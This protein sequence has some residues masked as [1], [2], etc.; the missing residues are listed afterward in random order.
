M[1]VISDQKLSFINFLKYLIFELLFYHNRN[2]TWSS[3]ISS[4][5]SIFFWFYFMF[6]LSIS[7]KNVLTNAQI[8][9]IVIT[10][11]CQSVF[12]FSFMIEILLL[13]DFTSEV[14]STVYWFL[15]F[16][17]FDNLLIKKIFQNCLNF[18]DFITSHYLKLSSSQESLQ[19]DSSI[20]QK[21]CSADS[22]SFLLFWIVEKKS[23]LKTDQTQFLHFIQSLASHSAYMNWLANQKSQTFKTIH[24]FSL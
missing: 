3:L 17:K 23:K 20:K 5:S 14:V 7:L 4:F 8:R 11:N 24:F 13:S 19:S 15:K 9:L 10:N 1:S 21:K 2:W 16:V 18:F 6:F 22:D 12:I